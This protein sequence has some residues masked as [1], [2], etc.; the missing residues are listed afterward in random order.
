MARAD[1]FEARNRRAQLLQWHLVEGITQ[2]EIAKRLGI[3]TVRV[4]QL[5][6][7]GINEVIKGKI[8]M[9]ADFDYTTSRLLVSKMVFHVCCHT[10]K[11]HIEVEQN[12]EVIS[13]LTISEQLEWVRKSKM[14]RWYQ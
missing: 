10:W 11:T 13:H 7:S 14:I 1:T 6:S 2:K 5:I 3:T 4:S 9:P 8:A 12:Y